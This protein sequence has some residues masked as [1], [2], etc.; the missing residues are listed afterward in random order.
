MPLIKTSNELTEALLGLC[1]F[2]TG[3]VDEGL[4]TGKL[5]PRD[6][7]YIRWK[8]DNFTYTD[9]GVKSAGAHSEKVTRKD[10]FHAIIVLEK[11]FENSQEY[12]AALKLLAPSFND[13]AQAKNA[14]GTFVRR[15]L[16]EYLQADQR[17]K[18]EFSRL[19][20][21][22][23][24][25]LQGAPRKYLAEIELQGIALRPEEIELDFEVTL[26]QTKRQD[27]EVEYSEPIFMQ[28]RG[29][30]PSAIME[31]NSIRTGVGT[32]GGA[33][34]QTQIEHVVTALR[35]FKVG[36]VKW[37]GYNLRTESVL[38]T[39]GSH[40][41]T[42]G[43]QGFAL[44]TCL[45][46]EGDAD[47]LIEF[48]QSIRN[49]IPASF[50]SFGAGIAD[51]LTLAYN[52]YTDALLQNGIQERRIANAISGLESLFLKGG[53]EVQEL[54]YRLGLRVS[55]LLAL[56]GRDPSEI[57][58]NLLDAY[59]VRSLFAHGSQLAYKE[60]KRLESRH[61]DVHNL[62]M[63]VLDYLRICL[64]ISIYLNVEK[65]EFVDLIDVTLIDK[66]R[67]EQ[68]ASLI[69]IPVKMVMIAHE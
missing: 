36:S 48:W 57:R 29:G 50:F 34:L 55:K 62:L 9:Q 30:W 16:T 22:F 3:V 4:A 46:N 60:K 19:I 69:A 10:W 5:I 28:M 6:D 27:L 37:Q 1:R 47:K 43:S 7:D 44:E 67:E 2:M 8:L 11:E 18:I 12:A 51:H 52:R 20:T 40:R 24:D 25:D 17:E 59:H 68:L 61:G 15:A 53:G 38:D 58:R 23:Q 31:K 49:R 33:E 14:L 41:M 65:D 26:R 45:L 64:V 35:L 13:P 32:V 54:S 66:K 63:R 56:T 39:M 21:L 42:T